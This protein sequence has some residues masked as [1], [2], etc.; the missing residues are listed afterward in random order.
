[1]TGWTVRQALAADV[2]A[3]LALE[4]ALP[5]APHWAEGEYRKL[6]EP[7]GDG[8]RYCLLVA[9]AEGGLIGFAVGRAAGRAADVEAELESIA[10]DAGWQRRGV[11]QALVAEVIAWSIG[12]GA[13]TLH[14]EVRAASLGAQRLY[15]AAGFTISGRRPGYYADP[16]DD[17][18]CMRLQLKGEGEARAELE[19]DSLRQ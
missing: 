12:Q 9:A 6:I 15:R 5:T 13:W 3:I 14:L 11:G 1:M 19:A 10:V 8:A 18:L 7:A 17:A 4:R 2:P 16:A